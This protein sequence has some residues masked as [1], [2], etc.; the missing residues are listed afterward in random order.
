MDE[1]A[2]AKQAVALGRY[3]V[4]D[5]RQRGYDAALLEQ[6]QLRAETLLRRGHADEAHTQAELVL[7]AARLPLA[8][9]PD[10][11]YDEPDEVEPFLA[12][13]P[14]LRLPRYVPSHYQRDVLN[15]WLGM[16][17]GA[18]LGLPLENLSAQDIA[19]RYGQIRTYV[20]LPPATLNDDSSFQVLS[21]LAAEEHGAEFTAEQLARQWLARMP[22]GLTAEGVALA[23]LRRGFKPPQSALVDNPFGEWV[24]AAMRAEIWGLLAPGRPLL[25][26]QYAAR[27]AAI[28]HR[29]NGIYGALFVA[30][31]ISIAF[32]QHDLP[33]LVRSAL[34]FVP[35][36][37]RLAELIKRCFAWRAQCANWEDALERYQREYAAYGT[38]PYSY[39][40]VFP[41][42]AAA[43]LALFYGAGDLGQSMIVGASIGGDT[44]F[45]PALAGAILGLWAG[46]GG[47]PPQW[48]TPLRDR[49]DTLVIGMEHLPYDGFAQRIARL[50]LLL[51]ESHQ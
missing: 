9:R 12:Q 49:F 19:R 21:L 4:E 43:L 36:R 2:E 10:W 17:A 15:S 6:T 48:R 35:P 39:A 22:I 27:D 32:V 24:G 41:C 37:S 38:T 14:Q 25:A 7:A 13:V 30:A 11:P 46:E 5:V 31:L 29:G 18:A 16:T 34:A 8:R 45:A 51:E 33:E 20:R 50:G 40:H 42:L 26:C 44:D 3:T 47:L 23:N 1:R 28:S